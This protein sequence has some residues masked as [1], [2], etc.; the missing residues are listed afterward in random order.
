MKHS[1]LFVVNEFTLKVFE[2]PSVP[3]LLLVPKAFTAEGLHR[4]THRSLLD[5]PQRPNVTNLETLPASVTRRIDEGK[6]ETFNQF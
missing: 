2:V 3:G 1:C 5:F 6:V 4:W